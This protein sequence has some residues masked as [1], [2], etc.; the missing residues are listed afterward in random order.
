MP[1]TLV[2]TAVCTC[3]SC[4]IRTPAKRKD[5]TATIV[6]QNIFRAFLIKNQFTFVQLAKIRK[7]SDKIP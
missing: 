5:E 7:I 6:S 4:I 2:A 1:I 3:G